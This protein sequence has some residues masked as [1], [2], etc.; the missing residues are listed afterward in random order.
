[1]L[2]RGGKDMPLA[3]VFIKRKQMDINEIY[4]KKF[5][6]RESLYGWAFISIGLIGFIV[7]RFIPI[8]FGFFL[9]FTNWNIMRG[10]RGINPV[11]LENYRSLITDEWFHAAFI[12]TFKYV[13]MYVPTALILALI[14]AIILNSQVHF[15][16]LLRLFYYMPYISSI[17]AVS[18][19]WMMLYSPEFGPINMVLRTI[20]I[21]N[22][23]GWLSSSTWALPSLAIMGVWL[24]LGYNMVIFL[25]GLQ[26]IPSVYYE[27]AEIDGANGWHK[28]RVITVPLLSP[29]VFFLMITT[30]INAFQIFGQVNVMTEGTGGPGNSTYVFVYYIY[31]CAFIYNR[32]GYASTVAVVLFAIVMLFTSLQWIGQKK[33][34]HTD[35]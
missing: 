18:L 35:L 25:A 9:S 23:P 33:W 10:I 16:K 11:G 34:V 22:P 3:N 27:A 12:N 7:F 1:M 30:I 4:R 19:V 26:A 15:K 6:R 24:N 20:G 5:S 28:F 29:T 8:V 2:G 32:L 13:L 21:K 31:R 14:L 17:V